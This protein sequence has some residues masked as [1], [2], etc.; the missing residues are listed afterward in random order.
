MINQTNKPSFMA[1]LII[2]A[3]ALGNAGSTLYLPA[4]VEMAR[5][6]GTT[7]S[8][9]KL[10]L[11]CYLIS[12]GFSQLIY[13]PLSDAFGR[14]VNLI[15]GFLIFMV[16]S[17]VSMFA[18][19]IEILIIGR[20][21]E[22]AGIG[23]A[24]SVGYA[25]IRDVFSGNQLRRCLSYLSIFIGIASITA[26]LV[27]GYLTEY[28]GWRSCFAMLIFI[29]FVLLVLKLLF[30]PETNKNLNRDA[31]HPKVALRNYKF[32]LKS[33]EVMRY[34]ISASIGFAALLVINA[35][36]PFIVIDRLH[37]SPSKYGLL[38]MCIGA[39][40]VLGAFCG[41]AIS[42]RVSKFR[43]VVIGIVLAMCLTIFSLIFTGYFFNVGTVIGS[44]TMI[45][46]GIGFIVP[47]SSSGAMEPFPQLAGSE[48]ALLGSM[49]F[50]VSALFTAA[51]SHLSGNTAAPMNFLLI[52]MFLL[53]FIS[54]IFLRKTK[55]A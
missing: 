41:S 18:N 11:S 30:L 23:T 16:G 1:A 5:D 22:G 8:A 54:F 14:K 39:G 13:G 36:L 52:G 10:T 2:S 7:G 6:L 33:K 50:S 34:V 45:L 4:M 26:P 32:L 53:L 24:N 28:A 51:A 35:M 44:C 21:I 17:F 46:F 9:I 15:S 55:K 38:N 40:Y 48:A 27:G 29:C 47:T 49:M 12:F 3:V 37:V 42:H 25:L 19:S 31:A 43:T 20:V